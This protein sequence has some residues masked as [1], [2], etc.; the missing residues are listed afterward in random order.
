MFGL[1]QIS[2]AGF[3]ISPPYVMNENLTRG[4]H[5]E[6]KI[7]L[8]RDDPVEDWKAEL[9]INVPKAEKWLSIDKGTEFILPKGEK[10]IPIIVSVDVPNGA[11]FGSYKGTIRIRTSSLK[12]PEGG[13]VS[14]AL[15]GQIDVDLDVGEGGLFDFKVRGVK[16]EDLEEGHK[17]WFW[18][19]P[20]KIKFSIKIE[21]IGNIKAA[22]TKVYFDIYDEYE[23]EILESV[24]TAKMEKVNPFDTKWITAELETKLKPGSYWAKFK[25]FKK[26]QIV[27]EGKI[28]LSIL[29]YGTLP[30]EA[31]VFLG[32]GI[33][34]W[35]LIIIGA[36][37]AILGLAV[38]VWFRCRQ[39]Y[40][41]VFKLPKEF[42]QKVFRVFK[43]AKK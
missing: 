42:F 24:E 4:S 6:E 5:Y 22:P 1:I 7:I 20:G 29:P 9:T 27:N 14:I 30:K 18:Y 39:F 17:F 16:V 2:W 21:N 41:R 34:I 15:G 3:G 19:I 11:E 32:L 26:E 13:M 35:T 33:K 38:L 8:V 23:K 40:K 36:G 12:P 28:H 25:I 37:L 31:G 43:K 10:Q